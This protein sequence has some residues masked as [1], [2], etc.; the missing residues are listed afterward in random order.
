LSSFEWGWLQIVNGLGK[1]R[2]KVREVGFKDFF[3]YF[4]FFPLSFFLSYLEL[5]KSGKRDKEKGGL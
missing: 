2:N 1:R 4:F 3:F 5:G